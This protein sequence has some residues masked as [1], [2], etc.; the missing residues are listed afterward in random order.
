MRI[1]MEQM[2]QARGIHGGV[3]NMMSAALGVRL[4]RTPIPT[5]AL[6]RKVYRSLFGS[7][8]KALNEVELEKPLEDFRSINELFTR[9]VRSELRPRPPG[10]QYIFSPCDGTVQEIGRL[11]CD[12]LLTA[13]GINYTLASLAPECDVSAYDNAHFAILFLSPSDC[14]RIFSPHDC[15]LRSI[16]HVPGYRLLV[17]PPYQR[18]EFPV[19]TLNER[20]ILQLNTPHGPALLILVAG[21]GVGCITFPFE[22]AVPI[23]GRRLTRAEMSPERPF[24][25]GAWL[26]TFELGSTAILITNVNSAAD[27]AVA[28]GQTV[29]I[30]QPLFHISGAHAS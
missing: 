6:R 21:W 22:D 20:M 1:R 8:Y 28:N 4:S 2:R 19:F 23:S 14:H 10:N 5:K 27:A 3:L 17:H 18:K 13:K 11:Q 7:K 24:E 16:T 26:A 15:T 30:G 29:Q 12:S 9:G 25:R